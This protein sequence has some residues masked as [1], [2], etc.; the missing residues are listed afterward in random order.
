[1]APGF[2]EESTSAFMDDYETLILTTDVELLKR[3]SHNEKLLQRFFSVKLLWY[4][5]SEQIEL[6]VFLICYIVSNMGHIS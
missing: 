2:G 4:S 5:E 6:V 3:A 1:M